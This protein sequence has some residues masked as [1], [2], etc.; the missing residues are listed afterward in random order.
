MIDVYAATGTFADSHQLAKDL[1]TAVI[2]IEQVP[3]IAMFKDNTAAFVHELP[4][5]AISNVNGDSTY[6]RVQVLTN[7]G[8]LDRDKQ[9]AV[10]ARLTEIVAE[11]A[12]DESLKDRTWVLLTEP[13]LAAGV[14]GGTPTP[15]RSSWVR[16]AS[17][18][19]LHRP[20]RKGD[21]AGGL[22][23][24]IRWRPLDDRRVASC[25]PPCQLLL[26]SA[27][28]P[29]ILDR[30]ALPVA[31][32]EPDA[33]RTGHAPDR[34]RRMEV[35]LDHAARRRPAAGEAELVLGVLLAG[36]AVAEGSPERFRSRTG[37]SLVSVA[38]EEPGQAS[39]IA[40]KEPPAGLTPA[41]RPGCS[42]VPT[43]APPVQLRHRGARDR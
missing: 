29:F 6:V 12:G 9:L 25:R 40:L 13:L 2:T 30:G 17:G 18:S 31:D 39:E 7:T 3:P 38:P 26:R 8:V 32:R 24:R 10:T 33:A 5:T 16:R 11:A 35:H 36:P 34:P 15:T 43:L 14:S 21:R 23:A 22:A 37:R 19:Q 20:P 4:A 28:G 41:I 42:E 27:P 1:A